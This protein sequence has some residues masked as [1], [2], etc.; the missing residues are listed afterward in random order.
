MEDLRVKS[1]LTS[2]DPVINTTGPTIPKKGYNKPGA[3]KSG[4][5]GAKDCK[6]LHQL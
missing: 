1:L 2:E 4:I 3:K 6:E 5:A